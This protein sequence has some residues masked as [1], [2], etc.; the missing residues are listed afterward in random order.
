MLRWSWLFVAI[1]LTQ[2]RPAACGEKPQQPSAD[3]IKALVD[4]LVS[5]N[6]KP[7]ERKLNANPKG[8]PI[9][10]KGF[11]QQ[12]QKAVNSACVK[13]RELGPRAFPFLIEHW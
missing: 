2:A 11:D 4:K 9:F 5:P 6:P 8:D 13:L 3:E 12:K 1:V 10:P 7:N